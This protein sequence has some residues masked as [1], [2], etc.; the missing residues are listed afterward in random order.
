MKCNTAFIHSAADM[1]RLANRS[2]FVVEVD[3]AKLD[4]WNKL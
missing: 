3:I 4:L 1:S 2:K